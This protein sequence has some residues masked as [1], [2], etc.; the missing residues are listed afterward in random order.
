MADFEPAFQKTLRLEGGYSD[1]PADRGGRTRYGISEATA[2]AYGYQGE[3][4]AL[5]LDWARRIYKAG[6]WDAA[7]LDGCPSQLSAENLFDCGVHCG[8]ATAGRLL[9]QA[10]NLLNQRAALWPELTVDGAI[11]P[12][13]LAALQAALARGM[14]ADL[15][16]TFNLY[17]GRHYLEIGAADSGQER[18]ELGWLRNR[19]WLDVRK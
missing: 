11:G 9:Q 16:K 2:R 12:R 7:Q 5:P 4:A 17:R 13:T 3:M 1:D 18:F 8:V 15:V 19:V 10:L 6:Y 14:E